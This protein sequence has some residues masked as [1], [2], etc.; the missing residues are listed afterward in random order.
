MNTR[1]TK[2]ELYG[3]YANATELF[4]NGQFDE[5]GAIFKDLS[6]FENAGEL[7]AECQKHVLSDYEFIDSLRDSVLYR[8]NK[9]NEGNTSF[10]I[11]IKTELVNLEKFEDAEFYDAHLKELAKQYIEGLRTQQEGVSSKAK[12]YYYEKMTEGKILREEVLTDLYEN[13]GFE[14]D[15]S[16][17]IASYIMD[18]PGI[19]EEFNAFKEIEADLFDQLS[20]DYVRTEYLSRY[21]LR[22]TLHNNTKYTYDCEITF[23]FYDANNTLLCDCYDVVSNIKPDT[24][25]VFSF[26]VS[27]GS[28]RIASYEWESYEYNIIIPKE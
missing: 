3:K 24:D 27:N 10:D 28:D 21:D 8:M 1:L 19:K 18:L 14:A 4:N 25:T 11:L 13:Y 20:A 6:D 26:Y 5:A 15:N 2:A 9:A 12:W 17:F 23:W 7:Y 16:E 22:V